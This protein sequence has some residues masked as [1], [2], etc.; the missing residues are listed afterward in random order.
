MAAYG[1]E[2]M[3]F[4]GRLKFEFANV[5][6]GQ[7][8]VA[9]HPDLRP[10]PHVLV[11][12]TAVRYAVW[13]DASRTLPRLS[14]APTARR[15]GPGP[16]RRGPERDPGA[17]PWLWRS[18]VARCGTA[19]RYGAADPSAPEHGWWRGCPARVNAAPDA[20][21]VARVGEPTGRLSRTLVPEVL[22]NPQVRL[23][24]GTTY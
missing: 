2:R 5:M 3:P 23:K 11:T 4:G 1:R 24:P 18:P 13:S 19:G 6:V 21:L 22:R 9:K 17:H 20:A 15:I 10:G 7:E 12:V 8:S 14:H 16:G